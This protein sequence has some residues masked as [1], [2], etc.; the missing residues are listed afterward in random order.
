MTSTTRPSAG[1]VEVGQRV[2]STV[3]MS[4]RRAPLASPFGTCTS[5]RIRRSNGT[6]NPSPEFVDVVAAD[7]ALGAALENAQNAALGALAVAPMLDADDD[8]IAMHRLIE[9]V[10]GDV[11]ARRPAVAG[12]FRDRQTRSRAD[13]STPDR[14]SGSSGRAG[15]TA[16]RE[17]RPAIPAATSDR[18]RRLNDD[19]SSLG[20]RRSLQQFFP[21]RRMVDLLTNHAQ[22]FIF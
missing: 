6:T 20:M 9:V 19:R 12:D 16:G 17:S 18:I 7:D 5:I 21:G 10:A 1:R 2:I 15:Q 3:T 4:P 13:W 22:D 14:R 11:D 8:A